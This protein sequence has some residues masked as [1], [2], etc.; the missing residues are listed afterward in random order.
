MIIHLGWLN[1]HTTSI[2]YTKITDTSIAQSFV[3][4]ILTNTGSIHVN[5]AGTSGHEVV[6]THIENPFEVKRKLG[7]VA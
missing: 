6:L 3:D 7:E 4:R 1:T 5:T 2:E